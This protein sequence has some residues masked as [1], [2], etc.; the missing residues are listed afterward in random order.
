LSLPVVHIRPENY[1]VVH[2]CGSQRGSHRPVTITPWS[3]SPP[4]GLRPAL[5]TTP[6]L[7]SE[8]VKRVCAMVGLLQLAEAERCLIR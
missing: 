5:R 7:V 3:S 6:A 1:K 4:S 8:H 2:P